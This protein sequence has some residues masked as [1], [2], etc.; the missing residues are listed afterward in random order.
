MIK[1]HHTLVTQSTVLRTR[2]PMHGKKGIPSHL[3]NYTILHNNLHIYLTEI[4]VSVLN[5]M[6]M[7][8]AVKHGPEALSRPEFPLDCWLCWVNGSGPNSG[9]GMNKKHKAR[10]LQPS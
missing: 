9:S 8:G 7:H 10:N 5:D 6:F 3:Q 2:A 1:I 4:A